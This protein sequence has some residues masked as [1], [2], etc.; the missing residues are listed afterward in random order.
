MAAFGYNKHALCSGDTVFGE[1]T[2]GTLDTTKI[3]YLD[4]MM[5]E[6]SGC[7]SPA[8]LSLYAV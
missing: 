8:G 5:A 1:V 7:H 6:A 2:D 4:R 3:A